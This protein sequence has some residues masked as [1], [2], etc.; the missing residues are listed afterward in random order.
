VL[1]PPGVIALDVTSDAQ[2]GGSTY[3]SNL[4]ADN[5]TASEV[6]SAIILDATNGSD[7]R[8]SKFRYSELTN[9]VSELAIKILSGD[10]WDSIQVSDVV[11][12]IG[13]SHGG[14]L[15]TASGSTVTSI[16]MSDVTEIF[17]GAAVYGNVANLTGTVGQFKGSNITQ[18]CVFQCDGVDVSGIVTDLQLS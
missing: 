2:S 14:L 15:S 7:A 5:I 18:T 4:V 10:T 11:G 13:V 17:T 3:I 12:Y 1:S 16:T 6:P 9:S 8:I